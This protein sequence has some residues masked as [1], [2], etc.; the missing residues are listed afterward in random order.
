MPG[1]QTILAPDFRRVCT[2][3]ALPALLSI[4]ASYVALDSYQ[5]YGR[6]D[7]QIVHWPRAAWL[8]AVAASLFAQSRKWTLDTATVLSLALGFLAGGVEAFHEP[9][10]LFE[11]TFVAGL[12]VLCAAAPLAGLRNTDSFWIWNEKLWSAALLALIAGMVGWIA[13]GAAIFGAK[14]LFGPFEEGVGRWLVADARD[15]LLPVIFL[16]IAPVYFLA[17][18][19]RISFA[20]RVEL[21][22][23]P[24]A[25][26][27]S[28][29][30]P[31]SRQQLCLLRALAPGA[32][33]K[34]RFAGRP[35]P[36]AEFCRRTVR[37]RT[38]CRTR[39]PHERHCPAKSGNAGNRPSTSSKA[40]NVCGPRWAEM[41]SSTRMWRKLCFAPACKRRCR[42]RST[43]LRASSPE[44][45]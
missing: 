15:D 43:I 8:A 34:P 20:R 27:S 40:K 23:W 14:Q 1:P 38:A 21:R 10:G 26:G 24:G 36:Y 29:S 41:S 3:F 44:T 13:A 33:L 30:R 7:P 32:L 4:A 18:I 16:T 11:K 35:Q 45:G 17:L 28:H 19:P 6:L 25:P 22:R 12:I 37:S 31:L 39:R 42:S 2:W 5:K 9:A